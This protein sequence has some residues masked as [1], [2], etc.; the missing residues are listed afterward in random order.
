M[1]PWMPDEVDWPLNNSESSLSAHGG[2]QPNVDIAIEDLLFARDDGHAGCKIGPKHEPFYEQETL[3]DQ[4]N[5]MSLDTSGC[6]DYPYAEPKDD[7]GIYDLVSVS[8][9]R[10]MEEGMLAVQ[11]PHASGP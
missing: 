6:L 11:I 7:E 2:R 4:P 8:A 10:S 9:H 1:K 3:E 5:V